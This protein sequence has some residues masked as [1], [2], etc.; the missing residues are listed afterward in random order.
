MP[1]TSPQLTVDAIAP[2]EPYTVN[3]ACKK[4][5]VYPKNQD[6]GINYIVRMPDASSGAAE[7]AADTK[8]EITRDTP[9]M[10]GDIPFY[11][12]ATT[13]SIVFCREESGC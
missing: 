6:S 10:P 3:K 13:G 5:V 12:E 9:W 4:I 1:S 11:L 2:A 7:K 8:F